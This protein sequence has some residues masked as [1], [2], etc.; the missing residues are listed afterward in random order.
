MT[1]DFNLRDIEF[2][3]FILLEILRFPYQVPVKL[4]DLLNKD[5]FTDNDLI[6]FYLIFS[7]TLKTS[8]DVSSFFI[9]ALYNYK[10]KKIND[11]RMR[12]FKQIIK[13]EYP[14]IEMSDKLD[15]INYYDLC[16][17]L[18]LYKNKTMDDF[19]KLMK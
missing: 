7:K 6:A 10:I 9:E 5:K 18:Q 3:S 1:N 2:R 8:K 16:T 17:S 13:K 12:K 15:R 4:V 14:C 11:N 19:V